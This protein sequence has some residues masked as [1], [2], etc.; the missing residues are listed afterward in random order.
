MKTLARE[1]LDRVCSNNWSDKEKEF[2]RIFQEKGE[3]APEILFG[4]RNQIYTQLRDNEYLLN[5]AI[6][7][8]N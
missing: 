5:S 1:F 8:R 3:Y 6:L 2:V 7:F 4:K